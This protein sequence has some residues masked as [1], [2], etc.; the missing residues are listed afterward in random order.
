[1]SSRWTLQRLKSYGLGGLLTVVMVGC[2]TIAPEVVDA[3]AMGGAKAS[4]AMTIPPEPEMTRG[5]MGESRA[6]NADGGIRV[7]PG[8]PLERH[9]DEIAVAG[10]FFRT[11]TPV[12]LWLDEGGYDGYRVERRFSELNR[13][14]WDETKADGVRLD[15][16]NRYGMRAAVLTRAEQERVRGG[17]WDLPTLQRVVDQFVLHYDASGTSARC[18]ERLHDDRGL[19]IHFLLDV[20]GTIYQTIDLKE[21][22]WHATIANSRSIGIEIANIGA[23]ASPDAPQLEDWYERSETDGIT[24]LTI[25][26][27]AR[28]ESVRTPNFEG[29]PAR[30]EIV[31]GTINDAELFQYDL[32]EEQYQAL[33][34]L[35]A[36]LCAVFPNI[37]C[38][39]PRNEKGEINLKTLP[40]AEFKAF[41]GL[42]GHYH[43]QTNKIDPGPAIQWER[44]VK[45]ARA[46]LAPE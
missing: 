32:T 22:A 11:G 19:S 44:I 1:M 33:A 21:R 37:A 35:T 36:A 9:G 28:A 42:I 20:D 41:K 24:R 16:P 15:S 10:Q 23:Y 2:E 43:I 40:V 3:E 31:S 27:K 25:P 7:V 34:K 38:D 4:A 6:E 26:A 17:G 14:G 46:L 30:N 29:R 45:D 18:F 12:V 13:A 8:Q 5:A 39:F